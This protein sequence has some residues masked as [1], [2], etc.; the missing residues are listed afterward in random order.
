M[1]LREAIEFARLNCYSVD[2]AIACISAMEVDD[3][4]RDSNSMPKWPLEVLR[5][6]LRQR[7]MPEHDSPE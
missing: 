2:D 5:D 1:K 6:A 7:G 3:L 4:R